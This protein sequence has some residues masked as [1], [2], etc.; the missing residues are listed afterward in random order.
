MM[1]W[2]F[3]IIIYNVSPKY[4]SMGSV[5]DPL[6]QVMCFLEKHIVK[7]FIAIVFTCMSAE[8]LR[9][10]VSLLLSSLSPVNAAPLYLLFLYAI[11]FLLIYAVI[12]SVYDGIMNNKK[13]LKRRV[14]IIFIVSPVILLF[15]LSLLSIYGYVTF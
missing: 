9:E 12:D 7:I 15:S 3:K 4:L 1:D 10:P 11:P 2:G 14:R 13:M 8:F 5:F 6:W